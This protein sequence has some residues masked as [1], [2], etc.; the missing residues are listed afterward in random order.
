MDLVITRVSNLPQYTLLQAKEREN[1]PSIIRDEQHYI[2]PPGNKG[3]LVGWLLL[4]RLYIFS[5]KLPFYIS[6][7]EISEKMQ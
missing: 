2:L 4:F 5:G 6:V 7:D 3:L 1:R